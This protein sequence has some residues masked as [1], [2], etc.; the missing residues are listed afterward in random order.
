[1]GSILKRENLSLNLK[2]SISTIKILKTAFGGAGQVR[3]KS[4]VRYFE[5]ENT[6]SNILRQASEPVT[7]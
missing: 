4:N 3:Y 7:V 1:M 6:F 5:K 2:V